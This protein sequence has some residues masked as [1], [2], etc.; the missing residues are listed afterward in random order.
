M[1][2]YDGSDQEALI[3]NFTDGAYSAA[4]LYPNSSS[5]AS[6]K[7]QYANNIIY[8]LQDA[9]SYYYNFNLNRQSYNHTSKKTDAQKAATQEAVLNKAFRQAINFA[10]NRTSYGAQSNGK[11]G[12]AKVLR[13]T[14][15]RATN[16][17]FYR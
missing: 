13:N 15:T 12:A 1:T 17:C 16:I 2:Y 5:F 4:R 9:T 6:V 14:L 3:R 7:K 11:D 10:Y 8:S